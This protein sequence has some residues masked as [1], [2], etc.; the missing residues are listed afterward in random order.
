MKKP[1][2]PLVSSIIIFILVG[3][4][5][6]VWYKTVSAQ[7]ALT[8]SLDAQI[9]AKTETEAR[10]SS[11]RAALADVSNEET[12]LNSYFVSPSE[13][14][15][16]IDALEAIGA[17]ESAPITILSVAG[18]TGAHPVLTFTLSIHGTFDAVMRTVGAI[19]YAPYDLSITALAI[20]KDASNAWHA[21]MTISVVA[22]NVSATSTPTTGN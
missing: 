15:P 4:G 2:L 9:N 10:I 14:V 20:G 12:L 5:Y 17:G 11:A 3:I 8:A 13:V 7:S 16:F 22:T 6:L 1:I 21:D 19:E 18:G